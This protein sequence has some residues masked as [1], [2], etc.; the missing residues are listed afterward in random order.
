MH[1]V[2]FQ[3]DHSSKV[4]EVIL[5][6]KKIKSADPEAKA[7]VLSSVSAILIAEIR[8]PF[9]GSNLFIRFKPMKTVSSLWR[10]GKALVCSRKVLG[11]NPGFD[12]PVFANETA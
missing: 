10:R 3:G 7:V 4:R 11:S 1:S 12:S 9:L 8:N 2:L 6:L 5:S